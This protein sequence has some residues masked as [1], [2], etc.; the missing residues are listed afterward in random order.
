MRES[1]IILP[2]LLSLS[3]LFLSAYEVKNN[4]CLFEG[5]FKIQ[6]GVFLFEIS[7]F[8]LEISTFFYHANLISDDVILF[9][10]KKWK[11]LN[12]RYLW[13]Y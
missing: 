5:P 11:I 12:R 10:T 3:F 1:E 8:V 7:F 13:K 2:F 6:N 4:L 9:A